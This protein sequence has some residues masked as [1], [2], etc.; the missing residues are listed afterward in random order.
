MLAC[1][2]QQLPELPCLSPLSAQPLG[3]PETVGDDVVGDGEGDE[4]EHDELEDDGEVE[5]ESIVAAA[6]PSYSARNSSVVKRGYVDDESSADE[7]GGSGKKRLRVDMK[8]ARRVDIS[9]SA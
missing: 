8:E 6:T 7:V 5:R 9:A 4:E 3:L 1:N 2:Q